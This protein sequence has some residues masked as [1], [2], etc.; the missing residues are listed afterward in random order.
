VEFVYLVHHFEGA[1]NGRFENELMRKFVNILNAY[2]P[3]NGV[4]NEKK[5]GLRKLSKLKGVWTVIRY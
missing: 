5:D 2:R 1:P 3:K 4:L